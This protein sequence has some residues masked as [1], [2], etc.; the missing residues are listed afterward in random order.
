MTHYSRSN[1]VLP[2]ISQ[3][4]QACGI[5][6]P[7]TLI[8]DGKIHRFGRKKKGWYVLH[9]HPDIASGAF[10]EWGAVDT[11][12]W[13]SKKACQLSTS[14]R[15]AWHKQRAEQAAAY[16]AEL[17]AKQ[18][19]AAKKGI[20]LWGIAR[21]DIDLKH[22]YLV[23]KGIYPHGIKQLG[24][25]LLIP[26]YGQDKQLTGCQFIYPDGFKP[27]LTGTKKQ[28]SFCCLKPANY[29]STD[30]QA[31]YIVEGWATG[32]SVF[33]A[34][35]S[36]VFVAF[37]KGNLKA[38]AVFLRGKYPQALIVICGDN[39]ADGGGQLAAHDAANAVNGLVVIPT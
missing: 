22:A 32:V 17:L 24:Q 21:P 18:A 35:N 19:A 1:P 28:G 34:M 15:E 11:Q 12:N 37:D 3:A 13:C 2:T 33:M 36:L 6:P 23:A 20:Y 38:V 27:Y 30:T 4:M 25:A 9:S 31:I 14:E 7:E 39:D 8:A 5:T 29:Q 10:G 26:V 16:H